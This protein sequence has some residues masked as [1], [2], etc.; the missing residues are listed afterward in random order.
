MLAPAITSD[1]L[2]LL[3]YALWFFYKEF[4]CYANCC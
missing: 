3:C 1:F 4:S 2:T